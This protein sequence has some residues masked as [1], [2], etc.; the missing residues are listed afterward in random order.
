MAHR[1]TFVQGPMH[2]WYCYSCLMAIWVLGA[3]NTPP[4]SPFNTQELSIHVYTLEQ[5]SRSIKASQVPQRD[6]RVRWFVIVLESVIENSVCGVLCSCAWSFDSH[7]LS[8]L[9][10]GSKLVEYLVETPVSQLRR[11]EDSSSIY[12]IAWEGWKRHGPLGHLN[13]DVGFILE[14]E[15][16]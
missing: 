1:I 14:T 7:S 16:R 6:S 10:R 12:G 5:H 11:G 13:E 9:V 2:M 4:T 15:L 3:I 8:R